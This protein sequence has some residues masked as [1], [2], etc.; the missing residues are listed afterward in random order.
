MD[1][2]FSD[3]ANMAADAV[4]KATD[5]S[6]RT[7]DES[8][9]VASQMAQHAAKAHEQMAHRAADAGMRG[10]GIVKATI[11]T[12]IGAAVHSF[13]RLTDQ[14]SSTMGWAGP[15]AEKMAA[16]SRENLDAI[17]QA[18]SAMIKGA[19]D[20]SHEWMNF[21]K[22]A[23]A[24]NFDAAIRVKDVRSLQD[25]AAMQSDLWRENLSR[26]IEGGRK[27][28]EIYS[29]TTEAAAERVRDHDRM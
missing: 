12:G 13:E 28:A 25:L 9:K 22:D 27:V 18:N 5:A 23:F 26:A 14:L 17:S 21:A 16:R 7:I 15:E 2:Q 19:E 10:A 4:N 3:Q 11:E 29:K 6:R 24:K 8:G 1:D 20:M